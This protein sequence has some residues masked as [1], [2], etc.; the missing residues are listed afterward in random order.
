MKRIISVSTCLTLLVLLTG[1][2]AVV[3]GTAAGAAG[4][5]VGKDERP[6]GV[7]GQ[8]ARITAEINAKFIQDDQ[9]S[10]ADIDVDTYNGV[11]TLWGNVPDQAVVDRA[12][13]LAEA[14]KGVRKVVSRLKIIP[15]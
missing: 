7:I 6:A 15:D 12:I 9:V 8:D 1:C 5:Y 4:Y 11:V 14:V 13:L 3:V 2:A 10:A